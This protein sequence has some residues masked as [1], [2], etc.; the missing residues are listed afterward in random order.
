MRGGIICK[1]ANGYVAFCFRIAVVFPYPVIHD[2]IRSWM[3][4]TILKIF[5]H[6]VLFMFIPW[7]LTGIKSIWMWK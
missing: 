7:I 1:D 3:R 4:I 2:K 5:S 6:I